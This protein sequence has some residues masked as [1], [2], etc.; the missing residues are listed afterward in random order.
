MRQQDRHPRPAGSGS[1]FGDLAAELPLRPRQ[2]PAPL[3]LGADLE[4]D[5]VTG[6]GVLAARVAEADDQYAV[7]A[8][9]LAGRSR[10]AAK[11]ADR[12]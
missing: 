7:A 5:V 9:A 11:D 2:V 12:G 1:A 10:P 8:S 4:A 3:E 6:P